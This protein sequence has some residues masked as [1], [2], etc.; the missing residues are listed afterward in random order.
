MPDN[1]QDIEEIKREYIKDLYADY[2]YGIQKFDTQALYLS[3]GALAISLTF[4]KDIVPINEAICLTLYYTSLVLFG[5]TILIGFVA[6]YISSRLIMA[7]I[8]RIEQNDFN[9]QDSDWISIINKVI[10]A[11]LVIGIGLLITFTMINMNSA[12][13]KAKNTQASS[14]LIEKTLNDSTSVKIK[15]EVKNCIYIDTCKTIKN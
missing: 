3:S 6:H 14:I 7:R 13:K 8:K 2:R 5:L 1:N 11:T 15:G 12:N 4:L 9:V 10:I